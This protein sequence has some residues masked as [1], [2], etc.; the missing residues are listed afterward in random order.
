MS[1]LPAD[2]TSEQG[3]ESAQSSASWEGYGEGECVEIVN[4]EPTL[5]FR[6]PQSNELATGNTRAGVGKVCP[7]EGWLG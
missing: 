2:S 7:R 6:T 5:P 1:L 3:E 4:W